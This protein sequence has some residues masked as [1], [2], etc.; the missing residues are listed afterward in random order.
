[1]PPIAQGAA[2]IAALIHVGFFYL[3]SVAFIRPTVW[4][5]FGLATQ[6]E[7]DVVRPMA[8]NQGF[9]NLFL[10]G[11]IL[12]GLALIATGNPDAGRPVVL[13]ACLCMVGAGLILMATDR[14]LLRA[15]LLQ[16]GPPLVA[17][18]FAAI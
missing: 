3:E 6:E 10:A 17:L 7:A 8:V 16:L 2:L 12:A 5:R 18:V 1:M 11:G 13:F 14:R 9:Y 15:A 4:P